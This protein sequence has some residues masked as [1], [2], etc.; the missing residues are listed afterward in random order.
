M[1]VTIDQLTVG[2]VVITRNGAIGIVTDFRP[3]NTK[4]P[5]LY[6]TKAG[7]TTYKGSPNDFTAVI[8]NA[9]ATRLIEVAQKKAEA[10]NVMASSYGPDA[11]KGLS[12]GDTITIRANGKLSCVI[13]EGYN[14][15]RPK[16]PLSF[17][18]NGRQYKGSL[19]LIV[20]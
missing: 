11:I 15:R 16:N 1:N 12:V 17:T 10:V 14:P 5:V 7:T 13:Y 18:M 2:S 19:N 20:K 9:D 6:K 8:G 4:Y 3:Q